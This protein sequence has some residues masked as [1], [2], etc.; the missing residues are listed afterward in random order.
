MHALIRCA[1]RHFLLGIVLAGCVST[2][3]DL[4]LKVD[5]QVL[6]ALTRYEIAYLLQPGDQIEVFVYRQPGFSRKTIVRPDGFISIPLVGEVRAAGKAP[7]DLSKELTKLFSARLNDPKVTVIVEN[8]PEPM[9]YVVGE[10]GAAKAVPFRQAKTAAQAVAL[11]GTLTR[12]ADPSGVSIVRLSKDGMLESHSVETEGYSFPEFYMVLQNFAL[13]PN[14][15]VVVPESY[16]AQIVRAFTDVNTIIQ[17]YFQYR[18][19]F[20]IAK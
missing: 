12:G 20:E 19:L 5:V 8:P 10:V 16:R 14:D 6:D 13:M 1:I 7:R 2:T 9:V 18:L 3:T 15:L 4:K 11:A 17:P